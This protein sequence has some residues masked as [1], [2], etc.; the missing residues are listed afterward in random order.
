MSRKGRG[1]SYTHNFCHKPQEPTA[2]TMM[3]C[4]MVEETHALFSIHVFSYIQ[5]YAIYILLQ[6][7]QSLRRF[8]VVNMI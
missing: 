5:K 2:V 1:A 4:V 8:L 6:M 7:T 3:Y